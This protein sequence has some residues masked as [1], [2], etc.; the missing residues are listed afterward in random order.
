MPNATSGTFV[1]SNP[2]HRATTVVRNPGTRPRAAS[3]MTRT[4]A[5]LI[6]ASAALCALSPLTARAQGT[7]GAGGSAIPAPASGPAVLEATRTTG[8]EPTIDGKLDDAAWAQAQVATDFLQFDPAEGQPGTERTEARVLYGAD[9]L[10]VA[11]RAYESDPSAIVGQLTRR[12]QDSYSDLLAVM[13]DSYFDRRTAFQ[14]AV[15]PVGVKSDIYRSNDTNEDRN[16]D[17]VWDAAAAV[18]AGGWS[19]EFRIPYSQLRFKA[20]SETWGINFFRYIARRQENDVWAPTRRSESAVVSRF[21][22]LR[23][24]TGLNPP[25]RLEVMPYT[26]AKLDRAPGERANPF[27]SP[28]AVSAAVGADIKYGV[29]SNLTLDAT[30]NPDF[31]QVE[32]D[33]SQVNLT[34]FETFLS[35]RRPFFVEGSNLFEFSDWGLFYTRRIGRPPQ[36][37]ADTKDGEYADQ[38]DQGRILGAA[39]LS[40]KTSSGWSIGVLDAVTSQRKAEIAPVTGPRREVPVEPLTNYMVSR[41]QKDFRN[42]KSALGMIASSVSRDPDVAARY[43]LRD[44]AYILGL[45]AR[46]RFAQDRWEL[47]AWVAGSRVE[48]ST[49]AMIRTQRSSARYFQRPDAAHTRLDSTRTSL[50]GQSSGFN[51]NKIAGGHWRLGTGM[52]GRSPGF[53]SNDAGFM[54]NTDYFGPFLYAGYD[55]SSPQWIFR[56]WRLNYN[57][58]DSWTFGGE[59]DGIWMNVNGNFQLKNFWGGYGGMG[60]NGIGYD[61]HVLRGGPLYRKEPS[62]HWWYGFN[63]DNRKRVQLGFE[64]WA[65]KRFASN[66][67]DYG[68]NPSIQWRPSARANVSV[69]LNLN[70]NLED[71]QFVDSFGEGAG[72]VY[73]FG[74]VN[75]KTV[76]MTTRMD[77]AF[78]PTLTLQLYAQPFVAAGSYNDF[79]RITD[80]KAERYEDR[81][82]PI[83]PRLVGDT[84]Y[85]D[86]TP[87]PGEE[88]F[89]RPD[90]NFRQ[91]H[92]NVVLRWEYRPGSAL[93]VV[94]AQGRDS[95]TYTGPF[96]L[97]GDVEDLF[98]AEPRDVFMVKLSY[99]LNP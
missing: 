4:R 79:K 59:E 67:W 46:H 5:L 28:N 55:Q 95:D 73:V 83:N 15:N 34:D 36:G 17:A 12:D 63:S 65:D 42:G 16:W 77:V 50:S 64:G 60:W 53:E 52:N 80:S 9:A 75:Q 10:F 40:G 54:G 86:L 24:L 68:A 25:R 18:D 97:G 98:S 38:P 13:I 43:K 45:D 94:W 23:G 11:M 88:S 84:Y 44:E 96:R 32:A 47:R 92:S 81:F 3:P 29:T 30:L 26:L 58:G 7:R 37:S 48:G 62:W 27:W 57:G 39:K 8:A 71:V 82:A 72:T 56:R 78:T 61:R 49:D 51:L 93:F 89:D 1:P 87:T 91:F 14:F 99:W 66:S 31:G 6:V 2:V 33:P 20:G 76:G 22:E 19:A 70:R 74:R 85:A 90:F 41:I 21:G 35:E 69:G